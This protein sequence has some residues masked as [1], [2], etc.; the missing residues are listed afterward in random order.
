MAG[1]SGCSG[2]LALANRQGVN[3]HRLE[4]SLGAVRPFPDTEYL[5]CF[6][7]E[8]FYLCRPKI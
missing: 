2:A 3:I 7:G 8:G 1:W 5:F 6:M 4:N